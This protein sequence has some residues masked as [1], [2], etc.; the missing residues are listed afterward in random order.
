MKKI[1]CFD[2]DGVICKIKKNHYKK[3]LPN[4]IIIKSINNLF[5]KDFFIKIFTARY[6]GRN[7][8]NVIKARKQGYIYTKRQIESWG[9]KFHELIT[10]K[11][12]HDIYLDDK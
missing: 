3:S 6:M 4:N 5:E 12:S 11:P 1:F 7:K 9:F 2:L 10:G 8:E